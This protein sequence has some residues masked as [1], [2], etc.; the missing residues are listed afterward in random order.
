M[1]T[2]YHFPLSAACR[3]LRAGLAEKTL[4][5][6]IKAEKVWDRRPEFLAINPAGE[7]P[8]L[9][10]E[11]GTTLTDLWVILEYLE[12]VY[13]SPTM[14]GGDPLAR[15][16]TRR[17]MIWFDQRFG[18]QVTE[19]LVG[20]KVLT[21]LMRQGHPS[22]QAIR[23]GKENIHYHMDYLSYLA[24]QR[25]WLA[26]DAL[27]YADLVAAAHLSCVDYVGDVPWADYP[28]AKLWYARI[29]SRPSFRPILEDLVPGVAPPPHYTDPD[30]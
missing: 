14:L 8:V 24:D 25:N 30:F 13:P 26:G 1:R 29:K 16:E 22:S 5:A 21:R 18:G 3:V 11:D 6:D 27:S 9:I 20:Q 15:A 19:N 23:A 4:E 7:V 2:L 28:S 10:D 12:E 17:L